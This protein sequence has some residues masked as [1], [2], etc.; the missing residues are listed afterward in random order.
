MRKKIFAIYPGGQILKYAKKG[1]E[2]GL[3]R[4]TILT[5]KNMFT[6]ERKVKIISN[7]NTLIKPKEYNCIGK[8]V[9][10]SVRELI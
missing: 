3:V 10:T 8:N 6:I 1:V 7:V 4:D 9:F 5:Y 2:S